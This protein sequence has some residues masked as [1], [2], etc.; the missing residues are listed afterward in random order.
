MPTVT[1]LPM[2]KVVLPVRSMIPNRVAVVDSSTCLP[3]LVSK[4]QVVDL[5]YSSGK[6]RG[7][8][9]QVVR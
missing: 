4:V 9:R 3:R 2:A 7:H 6:V 8:Q 5:H 1:D